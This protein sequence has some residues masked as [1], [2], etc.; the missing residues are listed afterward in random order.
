MTTGARSRTN[1]RSLAVVAVVL[2][3]LVLA[4]GRLTG[5]FGPAKLTILVGLAAPVWSALV[6][7]RRHR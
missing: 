1:L 5:G 7:P 6:V 4:I 2:W 3:L